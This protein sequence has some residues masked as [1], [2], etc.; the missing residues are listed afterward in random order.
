MEY[1]YWTST[2]K[3]WAYMNITTF[4]DLQ[5]VERQ[6][7]LLVE[8]LGGIPLCKQWMITIEVTS[9]VLDDDGRITSKFSK[10]VLSQYF[11]PGFFLMHVQ[12]HLKKWERIEIEPESYTIKILKMEH[13]A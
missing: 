13:S 4:D 11:N 6:V 9:P 10:S 5:K 1:D 12:A 2:S 3:R 8:A 7:Q